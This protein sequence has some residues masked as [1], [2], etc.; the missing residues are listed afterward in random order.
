MKIAESLT[1]HTQRLP[2]LRVGDFVQIQNQ[3]GRHPLKWDR[4]G[5]VIEVRQYDQYAIHVDGSG[6]I[7]MRNRKF[8]RQ[9]TPV[10]LPQAQ[11]TIDTDFW[12][13]LTHV[14]QPIRHTVEPDLRNSLPHVSQQ[15]SPTKLPT[16]FVP[17]DNSETETNN[18]QPTGENY[19]AQP[20]PYP[21]ELQLPRT[22]SRVELP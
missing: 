10:Y 18:R 20:M 13:S 19:P 7:T 4:T 14:P 6:R 15:C 21:P 9:Y 16:P 5:R 2:P 8:L 3:T 12:S 22:P 17:Q 11:Y 1:E